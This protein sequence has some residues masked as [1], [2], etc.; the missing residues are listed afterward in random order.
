MARLLISEQGK[1]YAADPNLATYQRTLRRWHV[2]DVHLYDSATSR[3]LQRRVVAGWRTPVPARSQRLGRSSH[4]AA[5]NGQIRFVS[6]G[7]GD[8]RVGGAVCAVGRVSPNHMFGPGVNSAGPLP[9]RAATGAVDV[10]SFARLI[11][12]ANKDILPLG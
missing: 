8:C 10:P 1:K 6:F 2:I 7:T 11:T 5:P 4:D 9:V 12:C 3:S